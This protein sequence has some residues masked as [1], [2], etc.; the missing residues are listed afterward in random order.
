[1]REAGDDFVANIERDPSGESSR[2]SSLLEI[3]Q[4]AKGRVVNKQGNFSPDD[5][6]DL[7]LT[8]THLE[9]Q[10]NAMEKTLRE[11]AAGLGAGYRNTDENN[12][13]AEL[14]TQKAE[15]EAALNNIK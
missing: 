14:R 10:I 2:E 4:E 1:M 12:L 11:Q 15:Y 3:G 9:T 6:A 5:R 13:L 7:G 8:I